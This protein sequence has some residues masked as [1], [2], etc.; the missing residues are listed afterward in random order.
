MKTSLSRREFIKRSGLAM[1]TAGALSTSPLWG[2][3]LQAGS[4]EFTLNL[5]FS[6]NDIKAILSRTRMDLFQAYWASLMRTDLQ[7]DR[8]FLMEELDLTNH[9]R[10]IARAHN[11]LEREAFV[12]A[13]TGDLERAEL[14]RL[15]IQKIMAYKRWDYHLEAGSKT[16]GLQRAPGSTIAMSLAYDW[17]GDLLSETE[18]Q[19]MLKQIGDKGCEACYNALHGMRHP[20]LVQGWGY[21]PESSHYADIDFSR[22]PIILDK[23]NLKAVP[24]G[25][26][27]VGTATLMGKDDR[28]ERWLE[29]VL[30]SYNTFVQLFEEDGSYPEGSS[31]WNYTTTHLALLNEVLRRKLNI[32]LFDKA[33]YPGMM[34]VMLS[35]A[36]PHND[37]PSHCVNFGDSGRSF[38]SGVGF[39][40]ASRARDPL[41]QYT[42]INHARGHNHYS[43]IWYDPRLKP[44]SPSAAHHFTHLDLDWIITRTGFTMDDLVVAMRSGEPANHEHADRNSVILKAYKEVLL[45]DV[46]HPPYSNADPA[47]MLR[48]SPAHNTVLVDNAGHQYHTGKE[49]T[50]A[51]DASAKIVRTGERASYVFWAS[52][53]THAYKLVNSDIKSVTRT[54]IVFR[55]IPALVVI[56]K[57]IKDKTPSTFSARW[58]IENEDNQGTGSANASG[59]TISRPDARFYAIAGGSQTVQTESRTLPIPESSGVF[60]YIETVLTVPE[61]APVLV[62][63]GTPLTPPEDDPDLSIEP[64]ADGWQVTIKKDQ[65]A[66]T[67]DIINDGALPEFWV[68]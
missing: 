7:D 18:K 49:G 19:E 67:I 20:E 54:V 37:H 62:M 56:D 26:L 8:L 33:N 6:E 51:A 25:A 14:A 5:L 53:A 65:H 44:E 64:T 60:P 47:W 24:L 12:Y 66:K 45:A 10:H 13:I 40:I 35:L 17:L 43:L 46:K 61:T 27:A 4:P 50:N 16:I 2:Q 36:M 9:I 15:A 48:T 68:R 38:M 30:H 32:D 58:H 39:W 57:L 63:A 1:G 11:I 55:E 28:A 34:N 41:A 42:S 59:F 23:T 31:Y 3:I 29:M 21:D 52:D 22:W